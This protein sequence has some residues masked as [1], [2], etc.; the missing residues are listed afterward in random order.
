MNDAE[1]L[2]RENVKLAVFFA[3]KFVYRIPPRYREDLFAEAQ[4]GLWKACRT[5]DP[6]KAAFSTYA[7][8]CILAQIYQYLRQ[9]KKTAR[10]I[11]METP[12]NSQDLTIKDMLGYRQDFSGVEV[13]EILESKMDEIFELYL[14]GLSQREIV[15]RLGCS[16]ANVSRRIKAARDRLAAR[17]CIQWPPKRRELE[18]AHTG[19]HRP[20]S[21]HQQPSMNGSCTG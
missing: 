7:G 18:W 4:L 12:L 17:L 15:A 19:E 21:T 2:Y 6:G 1:L 16:Q 10:E 11:S 14:R 3:A 9:L 5:F 13:N 8:K 20:G